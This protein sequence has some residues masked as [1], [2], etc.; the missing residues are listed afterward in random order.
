MRLFKDYSITEDGIQLK[1]VPVLGYSWY[2]GGFGLRLRRCWLV[3]VWLIPI[4][5]GIY[6]LYYYTQ[7]AIM[8]SDI[9]LPPR[10]ILLLVFWMLAVI[11]SAWA[12]HERKNFTAVRPVVLS[13]DE[14][15]QL[16]AASA[17]AMPSVRLVLPFLASF[18]VLP[19][20]LLMYRAWKWQ[21]LIVAELRADLERRRSG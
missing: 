6:T 9:P 10:I 18:L 14:H 17:Q 3:T 12:W 4:S 20:F 21:N 19:A 13:E 5:A 1:K 8:P 11:G 15:Q 7:W 2:W 16:K